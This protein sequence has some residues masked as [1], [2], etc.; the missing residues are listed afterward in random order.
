MYDR[1]EMV[2]YH[3]TDPAVPTVFQSLRDGAVFLRINGSIEPV[4][5]GD[6]PQVAMRYRVPELLRPMRIAIR[7]V[8]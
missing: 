7:E 1:S 3:T 5:D 2:S 8:A 6:I 4:D